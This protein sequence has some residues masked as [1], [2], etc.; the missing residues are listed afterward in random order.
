[1]QFLKRI[2]TWYS[3]EQRLNEDQHH[4]CKDLNTL[5]NAGIV[6]MNWIHNG[7]TE[8]IGTTKDVQV[9]LT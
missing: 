7:T 2:F 4:V 5:T 3:C 9:L 8:V 1:M 6:S